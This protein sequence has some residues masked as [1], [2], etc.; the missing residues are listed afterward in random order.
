MSRT[1]LSDLIDMSVTLNGVL[2]PIRS[3]ESA[4]ARYVDNLVVWN[5]DPTFKVSLSGSMTLVHYQGRCLALCC[6]HQFEGHHEPERVS[7]LDRDGHMC[8]SSGG[9]RGMTHTND[10]DYTQLVAFD[11]TEPCAANPSLKARFFNL[12][13][14]PADVPSSDVIF[15]VAAGFPSEDQAPGYRLAEANAI[16][17]VKRI[18]VCRLGSRNDQSADDALLTIRP[19]QVLNFDPEGMSG[20]S[21]FFVLMEDGEPVAY[22]GGVIVRGGKDALHVIKIG[23]I[24]RFLDQIIAEP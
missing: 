18:L 7:I 21:A 13:K 4:L 2:V 12:R 10:T 24:Q 1:I 15:I 17:V 8:T 3:V 5:D 23:Y 9:M 22:L 16:E 11:F 20:G 19:L 6:Q 14:F